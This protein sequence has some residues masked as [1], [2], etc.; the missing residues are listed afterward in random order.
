MR[1]GGRQRERETARRRVGEILFPASFSNPSVTC[2]DRPE[3]GTREM[4]R[5]RSVEWALGDAWP[6]LHHLLVTASSRMK[7]ITADQL[8]ERGG[9][10]L[11]SEMFW[12]ICSTLVLPFVLCVCVCIIWNTPMLT[13]FLHTRVYTALGGKHKLET[14]RPPSAGLGRGFGL[15]KLAFLSGSVVPHH[16][17]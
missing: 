1:G 8:W 9:G 16:S 15:G 3:R 12:L 5:R 7:S 14:E 17:P 13:V 11:Q 6:S 2:I 10:S 4:S